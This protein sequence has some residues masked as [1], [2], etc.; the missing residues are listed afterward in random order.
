[1]LRKL[2]SLKPA[3]LARFNNIGGFGFGFTCVDG[4]KVIVIIDSAVN[5]HRSA[6]IARGKDV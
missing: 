2:A 3:C 5:H 1:M 6:A 4:D